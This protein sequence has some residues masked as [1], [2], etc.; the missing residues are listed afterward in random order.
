LTPQDFFKYEDFIYESGKDMNGIWYAERVLKD[1]LFPYYEAVREN[2]PGAQ[3]FLVQDNVYLH[4]L[5]LRY[6]A[7][8]IKEKDIRF[9][10]HSSNS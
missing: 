10:P 6:C 5:G 9:A 8:E 2:N 4:A 3:V 1:L 7:P